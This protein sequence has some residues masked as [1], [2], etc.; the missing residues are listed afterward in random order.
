VAQTLGGLLE[1]HADRVRA[2]RW[3]ATDVDLGT[4]ME[5]L[6]E[7]EMALREHD[8]EDQDHPHPRNCVLNL[9]V[10]LK[11]QHRTTACDTMVG[12]LAAAHPLRAIL[13]R[14]H[15]DE[16]PSRL[17]AEITTEAHQLL[18][19]FPVQR[20]QI[21]LHVRGEAGQHLASLVGPLL[22]PDVPTYLW[23]SGREHLDEGKVRDALR[24]TDV[25]IV[26]SLHFDRPA[27]GLLE[28]AELVADPD[29]PVGVSDFRWARLWPWRDAIS[30]FFAPA[31]RL[32]LLRGL[33][34]V[35]ISA[36]G[37]DPDSRAGAALLAGWLANALGWRVR[38]V[39]EAD[40]GGAA[41]GTQAVAGVE[42][43]DPVRLGLRSVANERLDRGDLLSVRL[44][45][46]SGRRSYSLVVQR[47]PEGERHV[48]V[49][50][51]M[52]D[53]PPL[54]QRLPLPEIAESDL[55]THALWSGRRDRVFAGA[56]RGARPLLEALAS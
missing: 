31:G 50:I 27:A 53:A 41:G 8:A 25:L 46:R 16:G 52:D 3:K 32:A 43:A 40:G 21:L 1:L 42:G 13:V 44:A 33:R 23:W 55:L 51:E 26:E 9:V 28:L 7:Q 11:D 19:G 20:E 39:R 35:E 54:R 34:E 30:Q 17:D 4:V 15:A 24:F 49:T 36:A 2:R 56:L 29:A 22:V 47:H 6:R 14:L 38:D 18:H 10:G 12:K 48:H 5:K 37:T 45:G